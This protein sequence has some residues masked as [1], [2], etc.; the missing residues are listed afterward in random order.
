MPAERDREVSRPAAEVPLLTGWAHP[1]GRSGGAGE[2]LGSVSVPLQSA[3][4]RC[5]VISRIRKHLLDGQFR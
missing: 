4:T 1:G 5:I 2:G 3:I